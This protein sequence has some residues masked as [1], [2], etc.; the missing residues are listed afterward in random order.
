MK[1]RELIKVLER[2][3][4]RAEVTFNTMWDGYTEI[5]D[6][7]IDQQLEKKVIVLDSKREQDGGI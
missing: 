2:C 4:K 3:P 7:Y 1:V 6:I 5:G